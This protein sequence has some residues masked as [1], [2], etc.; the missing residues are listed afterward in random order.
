MPLLASLLKQPVRAASDLPTPLI[1]PARHLLTVTVVTSARAAE[2]ISVIPNDSS[3]ANA[4][5]SLCG[6]KDMRRPPWCQSQRRGAL[7][8]GRGA[9]HWHTGLSVIQRIRPLISPDTH[10]A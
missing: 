6:R 1:L 4:A 5:A 2:P 9:Q 3:T 8:L 10:S 7:G